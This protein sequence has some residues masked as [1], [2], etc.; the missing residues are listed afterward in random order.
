MINILPPNFLHLLF[1]SQLYFIDQTSTKCSFGYEFGINDLV[2][3]NEALLFIREWP[4]T[5]T[6]KIE[7]MFNMRQ[8]LVF[9]L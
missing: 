8:S 9:Y 1:F 2:Q 4:V 5:F 6:Y 3:I 7:I